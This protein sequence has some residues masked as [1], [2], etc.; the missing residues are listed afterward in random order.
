MNPPD[1]VFLGRGAEVHKLH[2]YFIAVT[3]ESSN[4]INVVNLAIWAPHLELKK[5]LFHRMYLSHL[6]T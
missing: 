3:G 5:R 6:S 4:R 1:Q 2:V